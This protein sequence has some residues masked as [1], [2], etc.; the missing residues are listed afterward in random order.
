MSKTRHPASMHSRLTSS[1]LSQHRTW[2]AHGTDVTPAAIFTNVTDLEVVHKSLSSILVLVL[3]LIS[4]SFPSLTM[5][6]AVKSA[7]GY[8]ALPAAVATKSFYELK[9]KLPGKDRYLDFVCPCEG[10]TNFSP[11]SRARSSLLSTL[12]LNGELLVW[13]PLTEAAS[14]P[15]TLA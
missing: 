7:L 10:S 4:S 13:V 2:K 1:S 3:I 6:S 11:S 5:F 15:S 14:L 9:A 8:E 12:H